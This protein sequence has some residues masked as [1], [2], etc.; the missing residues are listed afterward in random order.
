MLPISFKAHATK[1]KLLALFLAILM[2]PSHLACKPMLPPTS[3]SNIFSIDNSTDPRGNQRRHIALRKDAIWT[4]EIKSAGCSGI[5]LSARYMMTAAHCKS[6]AGEI[7]RSGLAAVANGP[8]DIQVTRVVEQNAA[9]D[10]AILEIKWILPMP[11]DQ[12]FPPAVATNR[13][14]L[15]LSSQVGEGD[16]IFTVGFPDDKK[17]IWAATYAEGQAKGL[18][19]KGWLLINVGTINGNSG[20][21]ILRKDSLMLVGLVSS[22]PDNYL[23]EGWDQNDL[24]AS[25]SWNTAVPLWVIYPTSAILKELFPLGGKASTEERA[26]GAFSQL[27]SGIEESASGSYLWISAVKEAESVMSCPYPAISCDARSPGAQALIKQPQ[28]GSRQIFRQANPGISAKGTSL[29][30]VAYDA[31]GNILAKRQI[32][33][34]KKD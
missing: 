9:L 33:V 20:G 28:K 5:L 14:S 16:V 11:S 18:N 6:E 12:Q 4:V 1:P 15:N 27:Y 21:G 2:G 29:M 25:E 31:Q 3:L 8:S 32:R 22:G 19:E 34:K 7:Y 10:Y 17:G 24:N 30:I 13:Q 26:L 23:D